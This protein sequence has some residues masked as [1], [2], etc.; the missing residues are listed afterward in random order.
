MTREEFK[1]LIQD[2]TPQVL[3]QWAEVVE[4]VADELEPHDKI[5]ANRVR[6]I[7]WSI[8]DLGEYVR[9]RTDPKAS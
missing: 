7:S 4:D 2:A 3:T 1:T 8:D 6:E 9:T 5:L